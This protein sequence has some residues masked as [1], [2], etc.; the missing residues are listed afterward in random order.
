MKNLQ[1]KQR[2]AERMFS[3]LVEHMNDSISI[4]KH[5]PYIN[6]QELPSWL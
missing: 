4:A 2:A 5:N 1:G 3:S 6:T